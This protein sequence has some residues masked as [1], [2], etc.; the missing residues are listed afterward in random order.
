MI[1]SIGFNDKH[2]N[3]QMSTEKHDDMK[4]WSKR[5]QIIKERFAGI[6]GGRGTYEE[7]QEH[8]GITR[9]KMPARA[10][11]LSSWSAE[12]IMLI[13]E[14]LGISLEWIF[15]GTGPTLVADIQS[16]TQSDHI[17]EP[18]AQ[19]TKDHP[20]QGLLDQCRQV[21]ESDTFYSSALES[22]IIAF[23]SAVL[24]QAMQK[25]MEAR[26]NMLQAE[27]NNLKGCDSK[28]RAV[29]NM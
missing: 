15:Y 8:L 4:I 20:K 6:F 24:A 10:K 9:G 3:M 21:L 5:F 14:K 7:F 16:D 23:N 13:H 18:A 12:D 1:V 11:S 22:N 17:G 19:Y 25:N 27:V 29:G 28:G 2:N 26:L